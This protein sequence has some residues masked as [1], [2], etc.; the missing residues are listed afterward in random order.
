MKKIKI[1]L[2]VSSHFNENEITLIELKTIV[3][4]NLKTGEHIYKS[5]SLKIGN[6][7][8]M[9]IYAT[10]KIKYKYDVDND[11]IT[12]WG[13]KDQSQNQ[14]CITTS[15]DEQPN[16]ICHHMPNNI[17]QNLM[18][19]NFWTKHISESKNIQ[20]KLEKIAQNCYHNFLL[21]IMEAGISSIIEI[22]P[23]P[24]VTPENASDFKKIFGETVDQEKEIC[25]SSE[26]NR[27]Q[28]IIRSKNPK[29]ARWKLGLNFVNVSDTTN[30]H[31]ISGQSWLKLWKK[32]TS[33]GGKINCTSL[34]WGEPPSSDHTSFGNCSSNLVGGHVVQGKKGPKKIKNGSKVYIFPICNKHNTGGKPKH[35]WRMKV[36]KNQPKKKAKKANYAVGVE[37]IYGI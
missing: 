9:E 1:E 5:K 19:H 21:G 24:I 23:L 3:E 6:Y 4:L 35:S 26:I 30:D 36:L 20:L 28:G 2:P 33:Y 27:L 11:E 18:L 16:L 13:D 25:S 15:I 31:K 32:I 22:A 34:N 17:G 37:L 8:K 10:L 7:N 14:L 12:I 29:I